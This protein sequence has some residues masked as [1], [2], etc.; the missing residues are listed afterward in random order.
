MWY[1]NIYRNKI[2]QKYLGTSIKEGCATRSLYASSGL[3]TLT[4]SIR[5]LKDN[6]SVSC[7]IPFIV[8]FVCQYIHVFEKYLVGVPIVNAVSKSYDVHEG[9]SV[10]M[11]CDV[12][13][14]LPITDV[15]WRC[16][17]DDGIDREADGTRVFHDGETTASL[18]IKAAKPSHQGSYTCSMKNS[19]GA[20]AKNAKFRL[21]VTSKY[22]PLVRALDRR[23][24]KALPKHYV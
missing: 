15:S 14:L 20:S 13:S 2:Y 19:C 17:T 21:T 16:T 7:L 10:T 8:S 24:V 12:A 5:I 22:K 18:H 6:L 23:I 11:E 1:K 4:S 9:R 3:N